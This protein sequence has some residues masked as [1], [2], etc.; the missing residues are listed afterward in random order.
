MA[1]TGGRGG[2]T[3]VRAALGTGLHLPR[4]AGTARVVQLVAFLGQFR[5]TVRV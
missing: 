1:S 5:L 3:R 2:W 4:P